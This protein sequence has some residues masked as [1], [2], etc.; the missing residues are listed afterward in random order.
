MSSLPNQRIQ[1]F[2]RILGRLG[3]PEF[4]NK[5][6]GPE[7]D[8]S[9]LD[10]LIGDTVTVQAGTGSKPIKSA[11]AAERKYAS[12]QQQ[13][14]NEV[15]ETEGYL[16]TAKAA[17]QCT[18]LELT[19]E[20]ANAKRDS[21]NNL[22]VSSSTQATLTSLDQQYDATNDGAVKNAIMSAF[23]NAK[24]QGAFRDE[25]QNRQLESTYINY[26]F[27]LANEQFRCE[28]VQCGGTPTSICVLGTS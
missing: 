12:L 25:Y 22:S 23:M 3:D 20:L 19:G 1:G 16:S 28:I 9:Y 18:S 8:L 7:G 24:N 21:I 6:F 2:G 4:A 13:I 17:G 26:T 14:I 5:I 10:A 15:T 11:L 27:S